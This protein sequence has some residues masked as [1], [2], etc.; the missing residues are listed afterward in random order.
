MP[1]EPSHFFG[2]LEPELSRFS[3]ERWTWCLKALILQILFSLD[4]GSQWQLAQGQR[5]NCGG[6]RGVGEKKNRKIFQLENKEISGLSFFFFFFIYLNPKSQTSELRSEGNS[7]EVVSSL[8]LGECQDIQIGEAFVGQHESNR[9]INAPAQTGWPVLPQPLCTM[10]SR[11]SYMC[12]HAQLL[13]CVSVWFFV[14]PWTVACQAPLSM[15]LCWQEY[16]SGLSFSMP[17][18]VSD[19]GI[20]PTSPI[21]PAGEEASRFFTTA[22]L[23]KPR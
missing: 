13:S 2:R 23:G 5:A 16:W 22:P 4:Y 10:W 21:A 17:G 12:V 9:K 8:C 11:R 14:T 18:H 6:G 20:E 15:G 7:A 1:L 3:S 19:P